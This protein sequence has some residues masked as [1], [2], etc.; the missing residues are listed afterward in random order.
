MEQIQNS[1]LF[2]VENLSLAYKTPHGGT[3]SVVNE[4]S[5]G[6]RSGEIL[7]ISGE[8]G[9]GKSS[10][11]TACLG[12]MPGTLLRVTGD[13]KL[14]GISLVHSR[15]KGR[16]SP[17]PGRHISLVPQGISSGLNPT[18]KVRSVALDVLRSHFPGIK[19]K[20]ASDLIRDRFSNLGLDPKCVLDCYPCEL[21]GG[22]GQRVAI[23]M[24]TLMNPKLTIADEPTSAVDVVTAKLV[25]QL[26]KRLIKDGIVEGV[27]LVSHDLT[28]LSQI[29]TKMAIMY[30]GEIVELGATEQVLID[31]VHPYTRI[32]TDAYVLENKNDTIC[33]ATSFAPQDLPKR[34][35]T[36]GCPFAARCPDVQAD[37]PTTQQITREVGGRL[38]RCAYAK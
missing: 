9:A 4:V 20:Q 16:S 34:D 38:L 10:L 18:C 36:K 17:R 22:M 8:S 5:F 26:Y 15:S 1:L 3:V 6:L 28:F 19:K 12:L 23:A 7:G 25:I 31:P 24:S 30:A 27:I 35:Q 37:C 29:A 13:L 32:L 21:S 11:A 2:E 33:Q 14:G